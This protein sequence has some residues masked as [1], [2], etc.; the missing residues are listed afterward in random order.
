MTLDHWVFS[1][2]RET[3]TSDVELYP[4]KTNVS[5]SKFLST[6]TARYAMNFHGRLELGL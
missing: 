4:R 6:T 1:K 2:C 3:I 5:K